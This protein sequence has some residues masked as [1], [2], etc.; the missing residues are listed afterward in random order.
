MPSQPYTWTGEHRFEISGSGLHE[1]TLRIVGNYRKSEQMLKLVLPTLCITYAD[2]AF[3]N[4]VGGLQANYPASSAY[5]PVYFD[6]PVILTGKDIEKY[7][8]I[9]GAHRVRIGPRETTVE[10]PCWESLVIP[11]LRIDPASPARARVAVGTTQIDVRT[12]LK[13]A[14][15]QYADGR[16]VGGVKIEKRHPD[17][18]REDVKPIYD[19]W[20]RVV[21]GMTRDP[22]RKALV[23]LWRWDDK[24]AA[25]S[26]QGDFVMVGCEYTDGN[27][28]VKMTGLPAHVLQWYTVSQPGWRIA[29]RC[30][31]P[32]A[33]QSVHLHM[34]AWAMQ[35]DTF[36]YTWQSHDRLDDLAKLAHADP[37]SI[38]RLNRIAGASNLVSGME[39]TLPCYQGA[40]RP[41]RWE[42]LG[43]VARRFGFAS[44]Q[45]LADVNGLATIKAYNGT[46]D[47]KLP[48]WRFFQA[49]AGDSLEA[50]DKQFGLSA[51][52]TVSAHRVHRPRVGALLP[53]EVVAVPITG[54]V[55][56]SGRGGKSRLPSPSR[57]RRTP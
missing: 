11:R 50:F 33:R 47:L 14:V 31:R 56:A 25:A 18:V 9:R 54:L 42:K 55:A 15:M 36:R 32:L 49:R 51:G 21:D 38:L 17:Y 48:R 2:M 41:E 13:V 26:G 34:H 12:P 52:S 35:G 4:A 6:P 39:I 20:I 22:L 1:D 27:G 24:V 16:H 46:I 7:T 8:Y 43:D 57:R 37:E 5:G 23:Q 44:T 53:D 45:E 40:Y 19:L 29:P 28:V 10:F 30:L 3:Q